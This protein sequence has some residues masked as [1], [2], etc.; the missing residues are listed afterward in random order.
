[1]LGRP[2]TRQ[3]QDISPSNKLRAQKLS[4]SLSKS[5][6]KW[7]DKNAR[8]LLWRAPPGA[9]EKS[10]PYAVWLSEIM[11]QQT[12]V[13][14]VGPYFEKFLAAW[15]NVSELAR[16]PRDEVTAAWA[17]LGYYTRAR[18]LHKCAS[19]VANELDGIF[20]RTEEELIKLPGIG[21]YTAAAI[22]AIA[23]DEPATVV[24]GNVDRVMVRLFALTKPIR[25]V[26]AE[27]RVLAGAL[28]PKKRAG[29]YAQAVMDLGATICTP[30]NP[31]C[32]ICPWSDKCE[33]QAKG[34][35]ADLPIKPPKKA[36][37]TRRGAAFWITRNDGA[38]LLRRR[39]DKGLLGG[40]LEIPSTEWVAS[41]TSVPAAAGAPRATD[42]Q[43]AL[44][45]QAP[46]NS[47]FEPVSGT[48]THTFTH[49][50]L[51]LDVFAT[52]IDGRRAKALN[53]EDHIWTAPENLEG[54]GLPTV[55]M[56]V[57]RLVAD[58]NH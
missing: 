25:E 17:G 20:P 6:L 13:A 14:T 27:I 29:D 1:M 31:S 35:A 38:V 50:H 51:E 54:V 23:F 42:T 10:D 57:V 28:T 39:A 48:V 45:D 44:L 41:A 49:F 2:M 8:D 36:K 16:A 18:N 3:I 19:V 24:D 30:R 34:I 26:K 4:A 53:G 56:K 46:V 37:P 43:K 12:T 33:A 52:Q 32:D 40:M 22:A 5:L 47:N 55:M 58:S 7:Y 9:G 15:P 11:L 21:P